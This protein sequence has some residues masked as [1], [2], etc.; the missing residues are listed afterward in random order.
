MSELAVVYT[1]REGQAEKVACYIADR[2]RTP[3]AAVQVFSTDEAPNRLAHFDAIVVGGS[4]HFGHHGSDLM[5]FVRLHLKELAA[6]PSAFFSVS[7]VAGSARGQY[8]AQAT[9][10][11]T[12]FVDQTGWHPD[13]VGIFAGAIKYTRYGFIKKRVMR[14]IAERG[15]ESTDVSRD[16]EL[17]DW[18]DVD[19]FADDILIHLARVTAA[20]NAVAH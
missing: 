1:T 12:E 19:A 3:P 13:L 16:H 10:Y 2:L 17:T 15:G 11:A 7:A 5:E 20:P 9:D 8:A 18:G 14:Q 4:V 6:Q